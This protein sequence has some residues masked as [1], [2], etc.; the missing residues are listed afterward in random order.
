M[1]WIDSLD[2]TTLNSLRRYPIREGAS[3]QSDDTLFTIPDTLIT[4]FSLS[5][6]SNVADRF[7]ISK[8]QNKISS[9][10][11][12]ISDWAGNIVGTFE[13]FS[14]EAKDVDYYLSSTSN[15][16]GANGKITIGTLQDLS[17][18]PAGTFTFTKS[19]TE[20]EPRTIIP[21]L[22]GI[23]RITFVDAF[24]GQYVLTGS[25]TLISRSNLRFS[26]DTNEGDSVIMDAGDNLGLNKICEFTNCV[27][28]ING[29]SPDPAN[30]NISILGVDCVNVSSTAQYT[31][32]IEDNCCS[33]CTG[34]NDLQELTDRLTSL[35]NKFLDLKN[36]Y[37]NVNNQL[38]NYLST[39]NSNCEC[40]A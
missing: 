35:E 11:L 19:S 18:L 40:P 13:I 26:T 12:E 30:G 9:A 8:I 23:D 16:T 28:S 34:C 4:D 5:A 15:Y 24:S 22:Q 39:I 36:N 33:P 14:S 29:I 1:P 25:A 21:G 38:S 3:A 37:N 2:W 7:F 31:L 17:E 32:D 10:V 6:S 27:K 20:F